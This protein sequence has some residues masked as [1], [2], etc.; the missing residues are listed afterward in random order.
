[1]G[2]L[3]MLV[4]RIR[5]VL[6][7]LILSIALTARP[8]TGMLVMLPR[9]SVKLLLLE[10]SQTANITQRT[11]PARSHADSAI[12]DIREMLLMLHH[13]LLILQPTPTFSTD[14]LCGVARQD[15][16]RRE[17]LAQHGQPLPR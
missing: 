17:L 11:Q 9:T 15:T 16:L 8:T 2:V 7:M 5:P 10:P 3:L 6:L 4:V 12:L 13:V 14:L 1:M